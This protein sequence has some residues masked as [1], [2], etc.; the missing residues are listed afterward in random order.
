MNARLLINIL[1][2]RI[3]SGADDMQV[4][5]VIICSPK[6]LKAYLVANDGEGVDF[7]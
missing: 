1:E 3:N 4:G 6:D 2:S 7:G 5:E